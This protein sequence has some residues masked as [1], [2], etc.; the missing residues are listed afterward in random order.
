ML[1]FLGAFFKSVTGFFGI[2]I[3]FFTIGV[4]P[5]TIWGENSSSLE[6]IGDVLFGLISWLPAECVLIVVSGIG[7]AIALK[8]LGRS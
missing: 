5:I 3:D 4:K 1:D 6:R 7:I 2:L 8:V